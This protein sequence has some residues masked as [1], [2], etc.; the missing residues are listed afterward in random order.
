MTVKGVQI[1]KKKV[2]KTFSTAIDFLFH[3]IEHMFYS[4][5][6]LFSML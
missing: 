4:N 5:F 6:N 3:L 1:V 2:S